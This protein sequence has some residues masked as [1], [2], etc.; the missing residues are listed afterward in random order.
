[1]PK[2]DEYLTVEEIKQIVV[3]VKKVTKETKHELLEHSNRKH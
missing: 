3:Y 2:W 1:M